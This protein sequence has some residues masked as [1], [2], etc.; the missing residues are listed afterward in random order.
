MFITAARALAEQV[1]PAELERGLIYPPQSRIFATELYL[2]KCL[3]ESIFANRLARV[4]RPA[5]LSGFIEAR[6]HKP[7]YPVIV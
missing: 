4:A 7:E 2:A 1:T 5:D 3:V 6:L